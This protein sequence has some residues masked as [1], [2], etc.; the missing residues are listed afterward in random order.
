M[1]R[2]AVSEKVV[3]IGRLLSE[4]YAFWRE[5]TYARMVEF[6]FGDISESHS[7][8]FRYCKECPRRTVELARLAG[9]TKQSMGYLVAAMEKAGY[10]ELVPDPA[11]QRAQLVQF[12]ARG[13]KAEATLMAI[14]IE[15]EQELATRIGESALVEL[16]ELLMRIP[17][18]Q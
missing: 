5:A 14:S 15:L 8:I 3:R 16:R 11:D 13:E 17:D 4:S 6:G 10:V 1:E 2:I 18:E 12:T 7:P 9:M